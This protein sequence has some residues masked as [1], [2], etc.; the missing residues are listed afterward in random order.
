MRVLDCN[1]CGETISAA[2]DTELQATVQ[3]HL[4]DEHDEVLGDEEAEEF[5]AE[6][7]YDATDS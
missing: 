6:N 5:V 3:A 7:A 4:R 2:N 1:E